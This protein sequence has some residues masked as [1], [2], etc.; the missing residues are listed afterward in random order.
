MKTKADLGHEGGLKGE[1]ETAIPSA[2]SGIAAD[3]REGLPIL[4]G[5]GL[6][7]RELEAA[8]AMS[9][10]ALLATPDVD[11]VVVAGDLVVLLVGWEVMG[12]CSY[13]LIGHDRR[14]PEAPRAAVKAFLVT[15]VGDV[16]FL[17]GIVIAV[18]CLGSLAGGFVYGTMARRIDPI[19]LLLFLAALTVPAAL[20]PSWWTLA[21]L[22]VPST[23]FCA[24]LISSTSKDS[25]SAR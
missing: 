10:C 13:L 5:R 4:V 25:S 19:V 6:A 14:L 11:V 16:G 2:Q 21:L 7:L 15:R 1:P 3:W 9:L 12:I 24:P 18:W 23:V 8:D 20:A 17:L 22:L